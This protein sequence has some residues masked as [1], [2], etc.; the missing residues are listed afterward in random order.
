METSWW[1]ENLQGKPKY[2]EKTC[3]SATLFTTNPTWPD[4]GWNPS[5]RDGKLA[6]YRLNYDTAS[7]SVLFIGFATKCMTVVTYLYS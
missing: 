4:L 7:I 1:N 3:P 6:T 5:R 2:S